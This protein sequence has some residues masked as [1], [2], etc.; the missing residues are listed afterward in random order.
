MTKQQSVS[1]IVHQVKNLLEGSFRGVSLVGEIT[2]LKG[3]GSGHI[4]F[5]VSDRQSSLSCALFKMDALRNPI[6]KTLKDGD[7]VVLSGSIGVYAPRGTFQLIV[8]RIT[9]IGKG[10]LKEQLEKLKKKLA[11]D[12]LFDMEH[13]KPIPKF[14]KRI[15]VITA[16]GAAALQDFLNVTRR[17]TMWM[18]VVLAPALVQGDG[19]PASIRQAL[20]NIIA[21]HLK[22][23]PEKKFDV[24]VLTRGGGSLED[25]WAFNDE[26]LAW[27]I[28]NCPIPTI[29]AVGHEVDFSISDM[30]A[31]L[32]CETPSA[33]AE[34]LSQSQSSL[35]TTFKKLE[36]GLKRSGNEILYRM[37]RRL[38]PLSPHRT[39]HLLKEDLNYKKQCLR[40]LDISNR[41]YE[42]TGYHDKLM[43]M[44]DLRGR[45]LGSFPTRI[46]NLNYRV[47]KSHDLM[48]VMNPENVLGRGYTYVRSE[49]GK[50]VT[51]QKVFEALKE[52][53]RL[54]LK[55][56]DGI[57]KAQKVKE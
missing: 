26:A 41:L 7:K 45:L 24:V 27:D 17:R 22:A 53:T 18:D 1:D 9:P 14:P 29:S 15:A 3:S 35:V 36:L 32:R 34:V 31:D 46:E 57:G 52:G 19:A 20:N 42:F 2:N 5:T 12:G 43:R 25:L 8:K 48:R 44:E 38:E 51:S 13:K 11:A 47:Q 6:I 33:A 49:E 21:Y 4:Y 55:F 28:Y 56:Y 50:V 54:D 39:L 40:D 37:N 10:D 16:Q 23:P 30:V